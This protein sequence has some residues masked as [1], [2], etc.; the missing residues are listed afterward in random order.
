MTSDLAEVVLGVVVHFRD[1]DQLD[2]AA[3]QRWTHVTCGRD[4]RGNNGCLLEEGEGRP[5]KDTILFSRLDVRGGG[6]KSRE[7]TLLVMS[8]DDVRGIGM[9]SREVT[10]LDV[11]HN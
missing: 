3:R 5:A 6:R 2:V 4:T 9:K 11:S 8:N 1:V 10:S 7:A